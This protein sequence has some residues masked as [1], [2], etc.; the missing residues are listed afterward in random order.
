M[1]IK[2]ML[3]IPLLAT[4]GCSGEHRPNY[5]EYDEYPVISGVWEEMVYSPSATRFSLWAPTAEAVHVVLYELPQG[6]APKQMLDLDYTDNGVWSVDADGDFKGLFYTFNV[7]INGV[8]QGDSPGVMAKAVG[9][10]GDRAAVVDLKSTDP[11][12][13]SADQRPPLKNPADVILY[14][15]HH[16]DFS[17]D[18]AAHMKYPGKYLALT[19]K[20]TTTLDGEKTGLDHLKELGVTHVHILPSFDFSSIDETQTGSSYNW[21]YD[22]K[23]Y[24]VPEGSYST[25]PYDPET[26]IREFKQ[27]VMALHKAGIRVVMD[28]VYNHTSSI[29]GSAF[30]R[31]VPGYFY[32]KDAEGNWA[33]GS[34]CG[35]ETASE[36]D[37]VRK[38]IVESV[39]FWAKEYHIDGFRF[40]LMG[41]HDITTMNAVRKSL[42]EI[43]PTILMYGEGWAAN[44]PQLL[45]EKLAMKMNVA[46]MPGVAAFSD[47]FRDSLR[48]AW[49]NDSKGAFV[50]GKKGHASGIRFGVVG[51]VQHPQLLTDSLGKSPKV[52]AK[53]PTQFISYVSCHDDLCLLDRLKVSARWAT[54]KDLIAMVKLAQTAVL[55]SQGI[56]FIY[57]GEELMRTKKGVSNSY[58]SPDAIN[59]IQWKNKTLY[60][61]VFDYIK[62]LIAMRKA[63][64]AFRLGTAERVCKY[65]TFLPTQSTDVVAFQLDG[66]G[67]GDSWNSIIVVYNA[68]PD[69]VMVN[70]PEGTYK[71]ACGDGM[72]NWKN[73]LGNVQGPV[74]NVAPR[75][76]LILYN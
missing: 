74:V 14:E 3:M 41:I 12:G 15:M 34:G 20:S 51:G 62:E 45:T 35:N 52:W 13:W 38:Y 4:L 5:K 54:E 21:G 6:G 63:H 42:N 1:S 2:H 29:K 49:G 23:N 75:S 58:K 16:R 67:A 17:V 18:T 64:P 25:N 66:R 39:C 37:M 43:D 26:R 61:D 50:I 47:E 46:Q 56:P 8:W 73:A 57:A 68:K 59:A 28:V 33:N 44:A 27:M 55:T 53:E 31:T 32:R 19:E 72:I 60:H 36:R 11:E 48:G 40:D 9:V 76:A 70:V 65:L 7:K 69:V 30:E 71:V 10:N 22:P 24:N